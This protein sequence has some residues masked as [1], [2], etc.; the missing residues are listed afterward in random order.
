MFI[1]VFTDVTPAHFF[2]SFVMNLCSIIGSE[3]IH[4]VRNNTHR[5]PHSVGFSSNIVYFFSTSNSSRVCVSIQSSFFLAL[6]S[7]PCVCKTT[8]RKSFT[9]YPCYVSKFAFLVPLMPCAY[10]ILHAAIYFVCNSPQ[11]LPQSQYS[12]N[13][14]LNAHS[15]LRYFHLFHTTTCLCS[16]NV[17]HQERWS[18][19]QWQ[20]KERKEEE[21]KKNRT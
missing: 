6:F 12:H 15:M 18:C 17:L 11:Y 7:S 13:L 8:E 9:L 10:I 14:T 3:P 2:P 19:V 21:E 1:H 4:I 5:H 20:S 16:E